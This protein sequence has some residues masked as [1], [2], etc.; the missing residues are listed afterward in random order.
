MFQNGLLLASLADAHDLLGTGRQ[1][2]DG[3]A[4]LYVANVDTL[5]RVTKP[6]HNFYN[7]RQKPK[8]SLMTM[9]YF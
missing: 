8:V 6:I 5:G 9:T 4:G 3:S 7:D 2:L 1:H